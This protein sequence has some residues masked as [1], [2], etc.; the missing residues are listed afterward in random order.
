MI[1]TLSMQRINVAQRELR[2]GCDCQKRQT[3]QKCKPSELLY[4]ARHLR[5][6][7]A[8]THSARKPCP[9]L[10]GLPEAH[11]QRIRLSV[12]RSSLSGISSCLLRT[13]DRVCIAIRYAYVS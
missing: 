6:L 8:V 9:G 11:S 7:K 3:F 1:L 4:S 2:S 13:L 12:T 5:K 10:P